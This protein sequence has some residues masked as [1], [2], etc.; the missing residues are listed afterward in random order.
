MDRRS[1]YYREL[2]TSTELNNG[3]DGAENADRNFVIDSGL[4]GVSAAASVNQHAGTPN[5]TVDVAAGVAYDQLGQ[6]CNIPA[7]QTKDVSVDDSSVSTAVV[8]A[9]NEKWIALFLK[10]TRALSDPRIDGNSNTVY[11]VSAESFLLSVVQGS[12]AAVG[13]AAKPALVSPGILLADI[14]RAYNQTQILNAN[15]NPTLIGSTSYTNRRQD[16]IVTSVVGGPQNL[17]RGQVVAALADV[18]GW[19]DAHVTGGADRHTAAMIDDAAV[20]TSVGAGSPGNGV[21]VP[22]GTIAAQLANLKNA[23][24]LDIN[25]SSSWADGSN[26]GNSASAGNFSG[27][28]STY[29]ASIQS[30]LSGQG[31]RDGASLVGAKSTNGFNVGSIRSCLDQIAPGI[32]GTTYTATK[33]FNG[34]GG[35]SSNANDILAALQ[36]SYVP[37]TRKLLWNVA[38]SATV[39]A[40]MY[41]RAAASGETIGFDYTVNA[42]WSGTQWAADDTT[43]PASLSGTFRGPSV[44]V[45]AGDDTTQP[46]LRKATTTAAWADTAWDATSLS[47]APGN[48]AVSAAIPANMLCSASIVKAW[49]VVSVTATTPTLVD[50]FGIASV[51]YSVSSLQVTLTNPMANINYAIVANFG[52]IG[53]GMSCFASSTTVFLIAAY[54]GVTQQNLSSQSGQNLFFMVLGKQ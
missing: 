30:D 35:A 22:A 48:P 45:F 6:R 36:T 13:T 7:L 53:Y 49:G 29:V 8:G 42:G 15:I 2:V 4:I 50:G 24:Y 54:N 47:V 17:R 16:M 14:Y 23:L 43:K 52:G 33:I 46:L 31:A 9:S 51:V 10:F 11:F 39:N 20:N 44:S 32:T 37:T 28:L 5:L 19:Y 18:V 34:T 3:F 27:R 1:Y 21:N 26:A 12:E 40:R 38:I 25:T 41:A